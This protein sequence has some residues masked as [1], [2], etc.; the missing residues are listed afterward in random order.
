MSWFSS[1]SSLSSSLRLSVSIFQSSS[2]NMIITIHRAWPKRD[3]II[4]RVFVNGVF[5]C[6]SLE[7]PL[8]RVYF[9]GIP[10]GAYD[11]TLSTSSKFRAVRPFIAAVPKRTGIMIHEGNT[12]KDTR[13]CILLGDNLTAGMVSNSKRRM[14]EI[15]E[16][17]TVASRAGES[18]KLVI[19]D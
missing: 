18:L 4:G 3:Y 17:L 10:C 2:K 8:N 9:P 5:L 15:M 14:S 12:V 13:G 1:H 16:L 11:I 19:H 6:N 7:P